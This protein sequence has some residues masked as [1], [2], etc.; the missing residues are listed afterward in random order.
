MRILAVFLMVAGL[1]FAAPLPCFVAQVD[2]QSFG[3]WEKI[4]VYGIVSHSANCAESDVRLLPDGNVSISLPLVFSLERWDGETW[5]RIGDLR[6]MS[7]PAGADEQKLRKELF[8]L[9]A[10]TLG[11]GRYRLASANG[12]K[13][14][15]ALYFTIGAIEEMSLLEVRRPPEA[16]RVP[17]LKSAAVVV[18][19]YVYFRAYIGDATWTKGYVYQPRPD[20]TEVLPVEVEMINPQA[21]IFVNRVDLRGTLDLPWIRVR[22]PN[23]S[24]DPTRPIYLSA[25]ADGGGIT[26]NGVVYDPNDPAKTV[27]GFQPKR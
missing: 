1:A 17:Y 22:L 23:N 19:G 11:S 10:A 16:N 4:P 7:F 2:R 12:G 3:D 24:L 8:T 27:T 6:K 26:V 20:F 15:E 14:L 5:T 25:T 13:F 9:D 21:N 18:D